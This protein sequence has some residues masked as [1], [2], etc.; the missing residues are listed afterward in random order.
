MSAPR[1]SR[2]FVGKMSPSFFGS[3]VGQ[4]LWSQPGSPEANMAID[5]ALMRHVDATGV[6]VLRF[7]SWREPTLSLGYFQRYADRHGHIES[8]DVA[9]VR[10]ATG[11]GAILH[12]HEL[13]YSVAVPIE[14][15]DTKSRQ[16][17]YRIMHE[18]FISVLSHWDV[19]LAAHRDAMGRLAGRDDF[20]CFQRRSDDDLVF[21][22]Y[23]V[24]GSAQRRTRHCVLQHGSLL[25]RASPW[26]PQLPGLSDLTSQSIGGDTVAHQL[27]KNMA[28]DSGITWQPADDGLV[29][30]LDVQAIIEQSFGNPLWLHRR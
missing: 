9:C 22:G 6:P 5:Q 20:L 8:E 28:N 12:H 17:L 10:R 7:Y 13:T 16:L 19:R 23:K 24:M 21:A 27:V 29:A 1:E 14:S 4:L 30:A 2:C 25:L 26:A 15:R 18:S 11:G 3:V